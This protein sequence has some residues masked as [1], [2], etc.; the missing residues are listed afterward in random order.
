MNFFDDAFTA[1]MP[2]FFRSIL[3]PLLHRGRKSCTFGDLFSTVKK[4]KRNY[5]P[6]QA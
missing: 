4:R 3:V 6:S 5:I 2:E 1:D